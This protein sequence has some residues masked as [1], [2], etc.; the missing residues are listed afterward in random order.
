MC[1]FPQNFYRHNTIAFLALFRRTSKPFT[2]FTYSITFMGVKVVVYSYFFFF[3]YLHYVYAPAI[4]PELVPIIVYAEIPLKNTALPAAP[5]A[6]P[7][8]PA[9]PFP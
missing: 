4:V 7:A 9:P 5:A 8:P 1:V 2:F 3:F 6:P